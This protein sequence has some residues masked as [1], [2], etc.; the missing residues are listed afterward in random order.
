MGTGS[1]ARMGVLAGCLLLGGCA[2]IM[3][4]D[5]QTLEIDS[6]PPGARLTLLD[7][8]GRPAYQ[9]TTPARLQIRRGEGWRQH[10]D[11]RLKLEKP[12]YRPIGFELKWKREPWFWAN[13]LLA[14]VGL[15]FVG[16]LIVDPLSGA[17]WK[18]D[19]ETLTLP[20]T[21]DR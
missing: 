10:A 5:T 9:A 14:P 21:P 16:L 17:M 7:E 1:I 19:P 4:G 6:S 3:A 2:T 13:W 15:G 8:S 18:V 12:G 11:Y 20:M